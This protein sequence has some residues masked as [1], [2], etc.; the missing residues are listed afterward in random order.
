MKKLFTQRFALLPLFL[1]LLTAVACSKSDD[2]EDVPSV[3]DG[4]PPALEA[5]VL[6]TTDDGNIDLHDGDIVAGVGGS[7]THL[8]IGEWGEDTVTVTL[9]DV[10]LSAHNGSPAICCYGNVKIIL[11]GETLVRGGEGSPA[12]FVA[13]GQTLTICG[14][15]TLR[16]EASDGGASAAI[17]SGNFGCDYG[18]CGYIVIAGGTIYAEG[19]HF[20]APAIGA[21]GVGGHCDGITISG[22]S[23]TAIGHG[24]NAA[25]GTALGI[26][27]SGYGRDCGSYCGDIT[28]TG[29]NLVIDSEDIGIGT[30]R[31]EVDNSVCGNI[32]I[33]SGIGYIATPYAERLIGAA[34]GGRCGTVTIDGRVVAPDDLPRLWDLPADYFPNLV[35][36][37]GELE[38]DVDYYMLLPKPQPAE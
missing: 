21:G 25:I 6:I 8:T 32:T 5:N 37:K 1:L 26:D 30:G 9:L 22:G 33:T 18:H 27:G 11:M 35:F 34:K 16:A 4:V 20:V 10:D 23:V 28:I 24:P 17:G 29:G 19:S 2:A 14:D 36:G 12:V 7:G 31:S 15:G 38:D 3:G 13:E